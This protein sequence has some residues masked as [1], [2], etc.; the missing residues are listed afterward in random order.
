MSTLDRINSMAPTEAVRGA[1]VLLDRLQVEAPETQVM[2]TAV[3]LLVMCQGLKLN[4]SELM[5]KADRMCADGDLMR[6]VSALR[7]YV[8]GEL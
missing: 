8:K 1:L 5:N 7:D 6:P 4:V 3:L 2:G